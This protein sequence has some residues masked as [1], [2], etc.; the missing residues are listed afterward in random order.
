VFP[1]RL[2]L[3]LSCVY[4]THGLVHLP[5][6]GFLASTCGFSPGVAQGSAHATCALSHL[7]V[8]DA[9]DNTYDMPPWLAHG[10]V[11]DSGDTAHVSV[12]LSVR[13][14]ADST[15]CSTLCAALGL[16]EH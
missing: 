5:V 8:E 13:D 3:P 14:A 1:L 2:F 16:V 10:F 7:L 6:H 15:L 9:R 11:Q 4:G 12:G